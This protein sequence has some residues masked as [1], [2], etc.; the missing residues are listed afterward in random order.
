[1]ND[2]SVQPQDK[3]ERRTYSPT[4]WLV[5]YEIPLFFILT[6]IYSWGIYFCLSRIHMSN[7]AVLNRWLYVA[8]F[9]PSLAAMLMAH[10][11]DPKREKSKR[12]QQVVLFIVAYIAAFGIEWLDHKWWY[13][14][15]TT[16]L[17]IADIVLVFLVAFVISAVLSSRRGIRHLVQGLTRWRIGLGWYILALGVWPA[18]VMVSNAF[19]SLLGL[20]IPLTP[21]HPTRIPIIPLMIESFF[22]YL[23]FNGPLNEEPGWRAFGITRLQH[24]FNPLT[25]SIIV[26]IMWG[27]WHVPVHMMGLF[28]MGL[29]GAI[30]RIFS[31]PL[32]ILFTWLFNHTRQSLLPVLILHA[33]INTTSL[34][35]ARNYITSSAL[36]TLVAVVL[37]FI[38]KMW[39]PLSMTENKTVVI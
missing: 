11:T 19:A 10:F 28:P 2:N 33:S 13:H 16:A 30:I 22:W 1:M 25:A 37:V 7:P 5:R 24:R 12:I 39:R 32:A 9:G 20:G 15:V 8:A 36:L 26:G 23:L 6:F 35:L 34:F 31:I 21:Y 3:A 17:I 4:T 18:L 14:R 27:L 38:D 29:Q